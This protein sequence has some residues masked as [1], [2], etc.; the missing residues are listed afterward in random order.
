LWINSRR[1]EVQKNESWAFCA[2]DLIR[3]GAISQHHDISEKQNTTDVQRQHKIK[4]ANLLAFFELL[5]GFI[6]K[7]RA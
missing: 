1:K 6:Q 4:K 7:F 5:Q 2:I 3:N